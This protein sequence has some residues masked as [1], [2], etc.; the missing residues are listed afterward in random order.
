MTSRN[1]EGS[2]IAHQPR[3]LANARHDSNVGAGGRTMQPKKRV[4]VELAPDYAAYAPPPF[5]PQVFVDLP[6][7][8]AVHPPTH[9]P[10]QSLT[11]V[12]TYTNVYVYAHTDTPRPWPFWPTYTHTH[13]PTRTHTRYATCGA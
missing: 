10:P 9:P 12:R 3:S 7:P 4:R 6:R 11:H 1:T 5:P 2:P 13:A 8:V